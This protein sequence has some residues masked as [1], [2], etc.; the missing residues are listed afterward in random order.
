MARHTPQRRLTDIVLSRR[1]DSLDSFVAEA[2]IRRL[3][4]QIEQR[5][6]GTV[7]RV[8]AGCGGPLAGRA[9]RQYCSGRCRQ[10]AL[11]SRRGDG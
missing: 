7:P 1:V 9:D 10:A 3:R 11:R 6:D 8:C 4:R 5:L 2:S